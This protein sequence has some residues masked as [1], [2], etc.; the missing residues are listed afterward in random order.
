MK[1]LMRPNEDE[2]GIMRLQ[3]C[4]LSIAKYIHDFCDDNGISYCLMGG[5]ALGAVRHGGFI[6]WD[7]DLDIFMTPDSYEKFRKLFKE[8]GDK[9]NFYLQEKSL[10]GLTSTAKLRYNHSSYIEDAEK[11]KDVHKG[12]FV[13]IF[14]L[15]TCPDRHISRKW[16]YFW[17]KYI[18]A[19]GLADRGTK[20]DGSMGVMLSLLRILP[21]T[22][23]IGFALKQLYKYRYEVS[24]YL[25]HFLGHAKL[26]K[27]L[28]RREYFS[29]VKLMPFETV[30]L[31]VPGH[32]E[33]YLKARWGDYMK[34]PSKEEIKRTQ[35]CTN[36]SDAEQFAGFKPNGDYKDE[37]LMFP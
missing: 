1:N 27:A 8:K 31:Y 9:E 15:H 18:V 13:D 16:Q 20:K 21:P 6:P 10:G 33:E 11:E 34:L 28:Y 30:S 32:V 36:W 2:W 22:S 19:K 37:A 14:I 17:A 5:S 7:D 29:S 35:H 4:I 3:N 23:L 25:C 24:E 26:N 12:V